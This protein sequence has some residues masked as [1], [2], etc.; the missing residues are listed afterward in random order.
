L[1]WYGFREQ[2]LLSIRRPVT[3]FGHNRWAEGDKE[4]A[5]AALWL[6]SGANR[7]LVINEWALEHC[8]S[9]A[10]HEE[11]GQANRR[12]WYVVR[13]AGDAGCSA[14]GNPKAVFNYTPP[15]TP[16]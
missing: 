11:I 13:G 15:V 5:D 4:A 9:K 8:F 3:H 1:G 6:A 16:Q 14:T 2:Y 7:V 10:E 12:S